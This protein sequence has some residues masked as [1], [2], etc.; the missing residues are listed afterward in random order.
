MEHFGFESTPTHSQIE[1]KYP[2]KKVLVSKWRKLVMLW[3]PDRVMAHKKKG[4]TPAEATEQ[5]QKIERI[6]HQL[7]KF[8]DDAGAFCPPKQTGSPKSK[9]KQRKIVQIHVIRVA[10]LLIEGSDPSISLQV[11][12]AHVSQSTDSVPIERSSSNSYAVD[13]ELLLLEVQGQAEIEFTLFL[14]R[15]P[16]GHNHAV[17]EG[18]LSQDGFRKRKNCNEYEGAVRLYRN[19]KIRAVLDVFIR[20]EE[21]VGAPDKNGR[22]PDRKGSSAQEAAASPETSKKSKKERKT[23]KKKKRN[24]SPSPPYYFYKLIHLLISS[25]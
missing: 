8:Y 17:G 12:A 25:T 18:K 10:E 15:T 19:N 14:K 16:N 2:Q 22:S 13:Q 11:D 4:I 3:H 9:S 5:F 24:R 21:L 1:E 23:D 20:T 6:Y 7:C